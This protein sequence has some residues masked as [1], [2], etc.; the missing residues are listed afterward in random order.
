MVLGE[1]V[2]DRDNEPIT[3][4]GLNGGTRPLTCKSVSHCIMQ[5]STMRTVYDQHGLGET[6]GSTG[7]LGDDE[8]VAT[9]GGT[10]ALQTVQEE[11]GAR[12]GLHDQ[13]AG[14]AREELVPRD[15]LWCFA[16]GDGVYSA[17]TESEDQGDEQH[18]KC[19][20]DI[21]QSAGGVCHHV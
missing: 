3:L 4:V 19:E 13:R 6:V 2:S 16:V 5:G 9:S 18:G 20:R 11:A 15:E 12:R 8:V 17:G 21:A 10:L 1:E 14:V 7:Q